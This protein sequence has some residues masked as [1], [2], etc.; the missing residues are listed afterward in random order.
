MTKK[1]KKI[2]E[3]NKN[4]KGV[5]KTRKNPFKFLFVKTKSGLKS[6]KKSIG[7]FKSRRPH[8]SF[9]L[10]CRRDYKR[11][12]KAP[13]YFALTLEVF[14]YLWKYK[15]TFIGLA[16]VIGFFT[17]VFG[18]VGSQYIYSQVSE[19][20]KNT[21]PNDLFGGVSGAISQAG[22]LLFYSVSNGIT[23]K[24][25]S[26]QVI[27]GLFMSL[28]LWLTVIWILRKVTFGKKVKLRDAIYNAG[29]P[30]VPTFLVFF[31]L[32][33]QLIP[34]AL[35]TIVY[36][37][38]LQT[39]FLSTGVELMLGSI[40]YGLSIILTLYWIIPTLFAVIIVTIP[41]MYP[42]KA[43]T[44]SGD[45]VTGRRLRLIYRSVWMFLVLLLLWAV[46]M[47]PIILFDFWI[48]DMFKQILW[49]PIV[50]VSLLI[51]SIFSVIWASSYMYL[52]YRKVVDDGSSPA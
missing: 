29:S 31:T 27:V 4:N 50:P 47:I 5:K 25:D 8:R 15:T 23:T 45:L 17:F 2:K 43:L 12:L 39:S 9:R 48:K 1:F 42:V 21:A 14:M 37:S 16:I 36:F 51:M 3:S 33:V 35:T 22:I 7:N 11:T 13:G 20:M 46:I 10:T 40:A 30:I 34:V 24:L 38:A 18:L 52:L 44:I 32:T 28:Y 26:G 6:I 41:G 19:L 49:M